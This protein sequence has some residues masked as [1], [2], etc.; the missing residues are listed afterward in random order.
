MHH[1]PGPRGPWR[2]K[3]GRYRGLAPRAWQIRDLARSTSDIRSRLARV[4]RSNEMKSSGWDIGWPL[5]PSTDRREPGQRPAD[6]LGVDATV[7]GATSAPG[8]VA[9]LFKKAIAKK[10]TEVGKPGRLTGPLFQ[11]I[12]NPCTRELA[13][14][15]LSAFSDCE[16]GCQDSDPLRP[17]L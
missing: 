2:R 15:G 17:L 4:S 3:A 9:D 6:S 10:H 11:F 1:D 5:T 8:R 14:V 16:G 12:Q 13:P 7:V